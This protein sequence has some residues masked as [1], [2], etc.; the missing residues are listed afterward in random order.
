M[1][2]KGDNKGL[3]YLINVI[4]IQTKINKR[5]LKRA[6]SSEVFHACV[7]VCQTVQFKGNLFWHVGGK[8]NYTIASSEVLP[9][10]LPDSYIF[11]LSQ[12]HQNA[13]KVS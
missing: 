5:F 1:S 10:V 3:S 6:F 2:P 13:V 4:S 7:D 12:S 9:L 8:K 11:K